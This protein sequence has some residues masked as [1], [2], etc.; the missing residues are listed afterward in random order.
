MGMMALQ[1][2]P[3]AP[4][5]A[6]GAWVHVRRREVPVGGRVTPGGE[7]A[8]FAIVV[9]DAWQGRGVARMLM[10]QLAASAKARGLRRLEGSVLRGNAGMLNFTRAFGFTVHDDPD[11]PD[12]FDVVLELS[13]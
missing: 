13:P 5:V 2:V 10:G 9:A 12:L 11:A 1:G 3:A 8:E 6:R 4:G 7:S